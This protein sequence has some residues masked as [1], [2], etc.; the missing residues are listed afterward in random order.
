MIAWT[1]CVGDN[2]IHH[3]AQ[4]SAEE[5]HRIW[6]YCVNG[7]TDVVLTIQNI[8]AL[9]LNVPVV[10]CSLYDASP[11]EEKHIIALQPAETHNFRLTR[12]EDH[13]IDQFWIVNDEDTIVIEQE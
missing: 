1:V 4:D 3:E 7:G 9:T 13:F 5:T 11:R 6:R 12:A 2:Y 8:T 10:E